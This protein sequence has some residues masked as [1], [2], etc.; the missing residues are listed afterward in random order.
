MTSLASSFSPV[1]AAGLMDLKPG[2][3]LWTAITF[4]I[5]VAVLSKFAWGPIVKM[6]D[7]RERTIR[8]ALEQSKKERAEAERM[9]AEQK[10]TL[11]A[12]RKEAAELAKKSAADIEVLRADLTARARK[13][14]DE[15]V[16]QARKQI[17]E[18]KAKAMGELKAQVADLAIDAASRLIQGSLDD[19]AQRK[20]VE[21]YLA[22][23]P[24]NRAA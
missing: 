6:L 20:L 24:S 8:E 2:L 3:V 4:L 10:E 7:E 12:A 11:A 9:M 16:A 15:L 23:L 1:L 22:Q 18:E 17:N 19:K 5:L 21:D 14:A 13:E